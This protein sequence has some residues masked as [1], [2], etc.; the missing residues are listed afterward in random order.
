MNNNQ[1]VLLQNTSNFL[2][3][4]HDYHIIGSLQQLSEAPSL[5]N[6]TIVW[7]TGKMRPKEAEA[8]AGGH[9]AGQMP[10]SILLSAT[11]QVL[12]V[13]FVPRQVY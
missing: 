8:F 3:Q 13:E 7:L 1:A 12:P 10:G 6:A 11:H 5:G 4:F 2:E 9:S